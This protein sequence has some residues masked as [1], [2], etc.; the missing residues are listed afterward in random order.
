MNLYKEYCKSY[1]LNPNNCDGFLECVKDIYFSNEVQSLKQY[2]Q[3]LDIDRLSHITS[4]SYLTYILCKRF[5]LDYKK[6]AKSAVM[7]D[8]FYYDWRDGVTGKWHKLH[9]YKHPYYAALNAKELYPEISDKEVKIIK[10]HM[11]PLTVL[12]PSSKEGLIVCF[13]DKYCA[14]IEVLYSINKNYKEKILKD[15]EGLKL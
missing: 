5:G 4:V 14:T 6:A 13:C 9:G 8:L 11:W 12:P 15:I 1:R 2:E 7:H 10:R 3:H